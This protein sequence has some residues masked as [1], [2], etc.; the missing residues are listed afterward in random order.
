M[1][2]LTSTGRFAIILLIVGAILAAK[3]FWW[4]KRPQ[5]AKVAQT[6]GQVALPDA[7][8]FPPML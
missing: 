3:V 8:P 2:R 5:Q 7:L 4:D 6:I 1:A